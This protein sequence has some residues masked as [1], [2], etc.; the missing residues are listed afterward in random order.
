MLT[1]PMS[2]FDSV[3]NTGSLLGH[4]EFSEVKTAESPSGKVA[5]KCIN[6][7]KIR[8]ELH[9]LKREISI[10]CKIKHTNIIELYNIYENEEYFYITMELCDEENLKG[11]VKRLGTLTP[12]ETKILAKKI[13]SALEYLHGKHICHRDIKPENILFKENEPKLADFGL[14]RLMSGTSKF[15]MVGTPYYLAPEVISG[16]YNFKCDVWSLGV[17]LF[18]AMT[19]EKP[20][21]GE[22]FEELFV[23]IQESEVDWREIPEE[24]QEFLR[25]LLIK[26]HKIRPTA[27]EA[28][29][30]Q[31]LN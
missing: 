17:V 5:V 23:K 24:A 25:F 8:N 20:F 2:E 7:G 10:M 6:L 28:L 31:W 26:N 27:G 22:G 4:G 30:H 16:S 12:S 3:Y 18:F 14:A 1:R 29:T 19:G 21:V 9:L 15:S 11:R 13:L